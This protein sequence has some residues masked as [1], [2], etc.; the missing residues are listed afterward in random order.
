MVVAGRAF[1][2]EVAAARG[3]PGAAAGVPAAA[4]GV[5]T[6]AA[7][8]EA[9]AG[10]LC[11]CT[12]YTRIVEAIR[13][14]ALAIPIGIDAP[15]VGAA[16]TEAPG[17]DAAPIAWPPPLPRTP[18]RWAGLAPAAVRPRTVTEA[19]EAL[20]AGGVRPVAGG[21]DLM[22][23]LAH[24]T[25]DR[26]TLLD[27]SGIDELRGISVEAPGAAAT[28]PASGA[29]AG[30]APGPDLLV[31]GALATYADLRRSPLV[32]DRLP[33]LA[34]MAATVGAAQIQNRGTV[35]GN[36]VNA[37]PAG[38]LLPVLL[39][40]DA[41]IV[42]RGLRG[43]RR[44]AADDFWPAYR[45]TACAPDELVVAIRIP[46]PPG[47]VVRHRKVGGRRAQAIGK[48]IVAAA[49]RVDGG[50]LRDVRIAAGSVAPVPV[51]ARAAEAA[52]EGARPDAAAADRAAAAIAAEIVPIDDVR[53]TADYRRHATGRVLRR[54][55]LEAG[56]D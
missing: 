53:S 27:L 22:I 9:I 29:A 34:E 43:E 7:I 47:R 10:D 1:L 41:T 14:A 38:D 15:D 54:M 56:R 6:D 33:A 52:L 51:R 45:R 25:A 55:V 13:R 24:A 39:A 18:A 46:L 5:P 26:V 4:A 37:S 31:I 23:Q 28:A 21:T 32:A 35:G 3:T 11:R 40:T 49:W 48:T 16:G 20:A 36:I 17:T 42:V 12:G 19:L 8:R 44:V 50:V 2:D 30:S